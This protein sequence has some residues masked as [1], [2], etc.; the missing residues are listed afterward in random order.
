VPEHPPDQPINTEL[1]SGVAVRV[2][3]VPTEKTVPVGLLDTLPPPDPLL[4]TESV[5]VAVGE[6]YWLTVNTFPAMVRMAV[7][8]VVTVLGEIEYDID[9]FPKPEPE[10]N[11]N[12]AILDDVDQLQF[13]EVVIVTLPVPPDAGKV[14]LEGDMV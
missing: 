12:H 5:Y 13:E 14:A 4:L 8:L 7:R 3:T 10:I 11:V 1:A 9:P 2:T 6:P